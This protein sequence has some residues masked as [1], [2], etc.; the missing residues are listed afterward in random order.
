MTI[1]IPYKYVPRPY[2][3]PILK[4]M[5]SGKKRAVQVWHRKSGK[6]KTDWNLTIKKAQERVGNY[7][8]IF[9]KL[10]QARKVVWEGIDQ[11]GV[12]F[13]DHI[14]YEI[15]NGEPNSTTML[16]RFKKG[17]TI[18]LIGSDTF[19]TSI[20]GNPIGSVFSEYS[21]TDPNVWS[22]LR[23]I[24]ANNGG[25]A[26]FNGT[27][28]GENH[29]YDLYKLALAD[30]ENW[31]CELLTVDDTGALSQETLDQERKEIMMLHGND[32]FFQ[33]EYYCNFKVPLAG[34]YYADQ[35]TQAYAENRVTRV[36]YED[37]AMVDTW[38][39]L[40]W[41][42]YMSVWFTQTIGSELRVIDYVQETGKGLPQFAKILQEKNYVYGRHTAP[43]D[44]EVHELGTSVTRRETARNLGIKFEVAPKLEIIE[45]IFAARSL[46][47]K[48]YFDEEKCRVG[49]NA[50]KS[51]H[52]QYDEKKKIYSD[53]PL[54]DWS[55]HAADAFRTLAVSYSPT[56]PQSVRA[57][58]PQRF[59]QNQLVHSSY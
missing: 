44:I 32:A 3:L 6:E 48:C 10:T 43:H 20:G 36:P 31:F 13:L 18:Q 8:Y 46:F 58:I 28:R 14:P 39:D 27:P 4:A 23:P 15:L 51:Y 29:F 22:Y 50:L 49:L 7:W 52:K 40:G 17:S 57:Y 2:Q 34:A 9:P 25:W 5:D 35:V 53:H 19:D 59:K 55:S 33:Q 47:R 54:H 11:D 42:D 41:D 24:L 26:V 56:Y 37:R 45:G 16:V 38:W 30:P 12:S 21:I 1:T